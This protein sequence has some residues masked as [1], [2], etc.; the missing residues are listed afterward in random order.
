VIFFSEKIRKQLD[1]VFTLNKAETERSYHHEINQLKTYEDERRACL[2]K[3]DD[4]V[5]MV[6]SIGVPHANSSIIIARKKYHGANIPSSTFSF[7]QT[8]KYKLQKERAVLLEETRQLK[9][10]N[11]SVRNFNQPISGLNEHCSMK[12]VFLTLGLIVPGIAS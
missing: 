7:S 1:S 5:T 8:Q 10:V 3:R 6:S 9:R 12:F 4:V 11:E 2:R